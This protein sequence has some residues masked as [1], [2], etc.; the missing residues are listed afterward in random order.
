MVKLSSFSIHQAIF[1]TGLILITF[2]LPFYHIQLN[3]LLILLFSL[4]WLLDRTA[5]RNLPKAISNALFL[6]FISF[7][8]LHVAGM[9]YTHNFS[10]GTFAIERKL[11]FLALPL[12]LFT[13]PYLNKRTIHLALLSFVFS[14]L[15]ITVYALVRTSMLDAEGWKAFHGYTGYDYRLALWSFIVVHPTYFSIYL[16][17]SIYTL[18]Y[19]WL[20]KKW[21]DSQTKRV[22]ACLSIIIF[23][24]SLFLLISRLPLISFCL[25]IFAGFLYFFFYS[26]RRLLAGLASIGLSLCF[27]AV[28]LWNIP[29][30][31]YR[32]QET[33]QTQYTPP[34]G[35]NTTST[36]LRVAFLNCSKEILGEFWPF[37]VGTGDVQEHLNK[38]YQSNGYSKVLYIDTYNA[39]NQYIQTWLG[40]GIPGL[41][42]FLIILF[43]SFS[44][45]FKNNN[46][47]Y[48]GFLI[49]FMLCFLTESILESNKGIV[50]FVLISILLAKLANGDAVP[51][52]N[53]SNTLD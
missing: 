20:E 22:V 12:I 7:F 44:H 3:S 8:F 52:S 11:S 37:G 35:L 31:R 34:V 23:L 15:F 1:R 18:I 36:N 28:F 4:N 51:E 41:I 49:L 39:H 13:S 21:L 32:F 2:T 27:I 50:F 14:C 9:I 16:I 48:I 24:A 47:L 40:L 10:A 30:I 45:A 43:V 19:F 46:Y 33:I 17:F 38:C 25:T 53:G 42:S 6:S 5:L 26:R 29:S